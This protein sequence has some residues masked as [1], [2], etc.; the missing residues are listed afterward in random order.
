MEA[1][2]EERAM[3]L[4][5]RGAAVEEPGGIQNEMEENGYVRRH[6]AGCSAVRVRQGEPLAE[7]V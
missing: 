2:K 1:E 7:A 6:N 5:I 4:E 3:R